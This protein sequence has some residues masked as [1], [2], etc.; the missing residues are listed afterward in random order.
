[1]AESNKHIVKRKGHTEPYDSR[2]LYASIY[3]SCLSVKATEG[4]AE[5]VASQVVTDFEDWLGKKHEVTA[6][7]I[8][9]IAGKHLTAYNDNAGFIYLKHREWHR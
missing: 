2:K 7:D 6:A 9:R 4:E 8:R 1:V 3:A 5:L